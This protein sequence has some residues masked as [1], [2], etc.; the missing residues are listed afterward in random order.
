MFDCV[1]IRSDHLVCAFGVS[2]KLFGTLRH[3]VAHIAVET[4]VVLIF[5]HDAFLIPPVKH[6]DEERADSDGD[7]EVEYAENPKEAAHC[8][9]AARPDASFRP[10]IDL[11]IS[12]AKIFAHV[13]VKIGKLFVT[14]RARVIVL[15]SC[16]SRV[17]LRL[18]A[19]AD[20]VGY[21]IDSLADIVDD[22]VDICCA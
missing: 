11:S 18:R 14:Y 12:L 21:S 20:S 8:V 1:E 2:L 6:A 16:L 22:S 4:L 7:D 13:R 9:I 17:T 10:R 5:V 19:R 3:L 15:Q